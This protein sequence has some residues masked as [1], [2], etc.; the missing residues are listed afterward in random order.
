MC[1]CGVNIYWLQHL[2]KEQR[3]I[4]N[5]FQATLFDNT[6]RKEKNENYQLF[7]TDAAY[8]TANRCNGY[9]IYEYKNFYYTERSKAKCKK[10]YKCVFVFGRYHG[11]LHM[12]FHTK[13]LPN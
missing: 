4:Q 12:T 5:P 7:V 11:E 2:K 6:H 8:K 3:G 1:T 10:E 13:K 9:F